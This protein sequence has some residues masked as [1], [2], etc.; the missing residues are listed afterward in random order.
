[1]EIDTWIPLT[2]AIVHS[3]N[4][5]PY[6][7]FHGSVLGIHIRRFFASLVVD[8]HLRMEEKAKTAMLTVIVYLFCAK[9]QTLAPIERAG[10][11]KAET[12]LSKSRTRPPKFLFSLL[13]WEKATSTRQHNLFV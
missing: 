3:N 11:A 6:D 5:D 9:P 4:S 1:M 13:S 7:Q 12:P 10:F 8:D 2:M